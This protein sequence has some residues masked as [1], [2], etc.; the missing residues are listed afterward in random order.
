GARRP[1]RPRSAAARVRRLRG[2]AV[3]VLPAGN[4]ALRAGAARP[5][6]AAV[7]AADQ[8][9][10]ERQPL[11]LHRLHQDLRG[12]A[13][14]GGAARASV[15]DAGDIG[16]GRAQRLEGASG[17]GDRAVSVGA[18]FPKSDGVAKADGSG[19]YADDIA[20]PRMLHAKILRSPHAHARIKSIDVSAAESMPGVYATV[21]GAEM[22]LRYGIIPWTQD[23][24]ALAVDKARYVGDGVAAVAAADEDSAND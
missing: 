17:A 10:A 7:A 16:A 5:G 11:P 23:E 24:Q 12:G 8:G 21:V 19:V 14:G 1:A 13:G 2:I 18:R 15:A 22:P 6:S 9:S 3:R 4:D 20:L